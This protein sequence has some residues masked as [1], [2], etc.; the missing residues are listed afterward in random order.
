MAERLLTMKEVL[1]RTALGRSVV[2][3]FMRAGTFPQS[4]SV[5]PRR[6]AWRE[7]EV[8]QWIDCTVAGIEWRKGMELP[9]TNGVSTGNLVGAGT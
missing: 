4:L 9:S 7:S 1:H 3:Q 5:S 6:R 2:Y 8:Q